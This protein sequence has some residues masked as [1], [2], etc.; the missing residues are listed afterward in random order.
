MFPAEF[1]RIDSFFPSGGF[2]PPVSS[3]NSKIIVPLA[4]LMLRS[5]FVLFPQ[6][7]AGSKHRPLFGNTKKAAPQLLFS[8]AVRGVCGSS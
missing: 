7:H 6:F 4:A 3:I 1:R 2:N 8:I 5:L